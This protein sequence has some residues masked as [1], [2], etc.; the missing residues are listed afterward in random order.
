MIYFRRL[1]ILVNMYDFT[2]IIKIARALNVKLPLLFRCSHTSSIIIPN[3]FVLYHAFPTM[4]WHHVCQP[5]PW[6]RSSGRFL[7]RGCHINL[8]LFTNWVFEYMW[9]TNE[10][11]YGNAI[12]KNSQT[13]ILPLAA[14]HWQAVDGPLLRRVTEKQSEGGHIYVTWNSK[15][16]FKAYL[17]KRIEHRFFSIST[18]FFNSYSLK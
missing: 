14:V 16:Y 6:D 12:P 18:Y 1:W 9:Y 17:L 7:H 8:Y 4:I 2:V 11:I 5:S 13:T 3:C 10:P 15:W